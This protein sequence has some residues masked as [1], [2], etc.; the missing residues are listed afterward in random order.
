MA[1]S[2]TVNSQ[3]TDAVTQT[4]VAV[5]G[6]ASTQA[7]AMIYQVAAHAS[8]IAMHNAVS[9]QQNINQLNP[10]IIANAI[11]IISDTNI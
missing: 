5:V 11:K 9:N 8:G 4:N 7:V 2:T 10:A 3:I 1:E 6:E